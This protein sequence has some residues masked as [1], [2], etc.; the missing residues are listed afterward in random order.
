MTDVHRTRV[1][2]D[3]P[4][5]AEVEAG[6]VFVF[7]V[8]VS[9]DH[10]CDL[11]GLPVRVVAPDDVV[12]S[13]ELVEHEG[14]ACETGEIELR[15]PEQVGEH[16]WNIVFPSHETDTCLHQEAVLQLSFKTLPHACSMAVWDVP[17]P[18]ARAD[19][20]RVKVGVRCS[21]ACQLAGGQVEVR[22]ES[23]T[24]IE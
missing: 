12:E 2:T 10:G 8:G 11:R 4:L 15:L 19:R 13:A 7:K 9:C 3:A 5:P 1:Y 6:V 22:D 16:T 20:V 17:S 14:A 24:M 21:V 18:V 23:G